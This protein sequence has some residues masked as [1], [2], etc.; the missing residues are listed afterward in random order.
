[1]NSKSLIF[2]L[3]FALICQ[4]CSPGSIARFEWD[5]N[6]DNLVWPTGPDVPRVRFLRSINGPVDFVSPGSSGKM[7]RFLFGESN[8]QMPLVAPFAV[9]VDASDVVWV[10]DSGARVLHRIDVAKKNIKY[11]D[12]LG[13][14]KLN[15]P[16]GVAVDDLH[17][18][19]YVADAVSSDVYVLDSDGKFLGKLHPP[20][21]FKRPAGLAVGDDGFLYVADVLSGLIH[22]FDASGEYLTEIKSV[23]NER[24][25][26]R[27]PVSVAVGPKNEIVILDAMDFH[28]EV[29]DSQGKLITVIGS[30]GD[31]LG[32]FARPKGVA[33]DSKGHIFVSDAAFDNIQV[34]DLAGNTLMHWGRTGKAP[35]EFNLPAGVFVDHRDRFFVADSYNQRIQAYQLL[36]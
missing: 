16:S 22:K 36:H 6:V 2:A 10:A 4:A 17:K 26:F 9:A 32:R 23:A 31:A 34:F 33:I 3:V 25:L 18:K 35:G 11:F 1:M 19:V 30:I 20:G 5:T 24:G 7:F 21:G 14:D 29:Q 13:G 8:E 28:L 27:R 15:I 12:V